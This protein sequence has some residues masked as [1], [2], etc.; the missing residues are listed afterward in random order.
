MGKIDE[1][2]S[3]EM[4]FLDIFTWTVSLGTTFEHM[5]IQ[6]YSVGLQKIFISGLHVLPE[7]KFPALINITKIPKDLCTV[8]PS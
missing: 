2:C 1:H 4:W 3:Q 5:F 8:K 6:K 7:R